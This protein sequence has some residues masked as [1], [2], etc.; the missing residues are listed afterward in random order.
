MTARSVKGA[1]FAVLLV[2]S[3]TASACTRGHEPA[4]PGEAHRVV[5]LGPAT[6]EALFAVGAGNRVVGR[7]RYCDFPPEAARVPA[8]GGIEPDVEAIL[9]LAPDLLVGPSG[10]WS[11]PLTERM[12]AH[13]IATWFPPEVAT[14]EDVDA[15][16]EGIGDRT[17]HAADARAVVASMD[18]RE[19]AVAQ[20]LARTE[21][22][23][24]RVLF[25]VDVQP[26]VAAGPKSFADEMLRRA[27]ATNVLADGGAW[28]ALGFERVV[29]LDPDVVV[30]ASMAES[31]GPER[32]TA[33]EA[34][35]SGVRAAREGHV[36]PLRDER[37][38][39][40]GPRIAEGLAVL[41]KLLHPEAPIP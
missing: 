39:R 9:Q 19:K 3:S 24:P 37:V 22:K 21:A 5:S 29:D 26:I 33:S 25:V 18:A 28:P 15:L 7:S 12:R 23:K 40:P 16:V 14:L 4:V 30:D 13:G 38:L 34:G 27:G 36:V 6:T 35:W 8:V 2:A 20:A 1:A 17:G 11:T 41:A 10:Q 32:I 31:T